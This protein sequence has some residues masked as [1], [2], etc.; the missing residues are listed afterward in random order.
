MRGNN[1][2]VRKTS[3]F[4][5]KITICLLLLTF[6]V[7]LP[8]MHYVALA[9]EWEPPTLNEEPDKETYIPKKGKNDTKNQLDTTQRTSWTPMS[10]E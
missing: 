8:F 10:K 4:R 5:N 7:N 3:L 9:D 6:A 1:F 2:M